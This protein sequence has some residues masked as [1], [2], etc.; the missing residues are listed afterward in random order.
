MALPLTLQTLLPTLDEMETLD[1][2]KILAADP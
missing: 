2:E 1:P